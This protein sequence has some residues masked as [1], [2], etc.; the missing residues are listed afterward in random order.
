MLLATAACAVA[1]LAFGAHALVPWQ[2]ARE[3][4][5]SRRAWV[6]AALPLLLLAFLLRLADAARDPDATLSTGLS[7]SVASG[8]SGRAIAIAITGLLLAD[9]LLPFAGRRLP[10]SGWRLLGTL[11]ATGLAAASLWGELLR[12]GEG[13]YSGALPLLGAAACRAT[14]ALGA[15]QALRRR[16]PSVAPFAAAAL[17]LYVSILPAPL[18]H[19]MLRL[20]DLLTLGAGVALFAA[21]R[22]VP[23]SQRRLAL[24]AAALLAAVCFARAAQLSRAAAVLTT[25]WA[26]P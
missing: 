15:A 6:L 10:A 12:L 11:G 8:P 23:P 20:P 1:L 21:A 22:W 17:A 4:D 3:G 14:V 9:A 2:L 26:A 16:Q 25:G 19:A 7:W 24:A 18:R 13:P 5:E